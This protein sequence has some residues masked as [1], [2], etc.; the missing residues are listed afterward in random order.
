MALQLPNDQQHDNECD[1]AMDRYY[2]VDW[3][4]Q[5][6]SILDLLKFAN[7]CPQIQRNPVLS[8]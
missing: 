2:G 4:D 1:Q 6:V 5:V 8:V 3:H 7:Q